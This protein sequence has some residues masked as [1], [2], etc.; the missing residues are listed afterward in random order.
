[1]QKNKKIQLRTTIFGG[2]IFL[3]I[4]FGINA[5]MIYAFDSNNKLVRKTA[6]YIPYPVAN[7]GT[8]FISFAELKD[9]LDSVRMFYE[10]QDFSDLGLRVDFVTND[11]K[12]RLKIKEKQ[13]LQ[14]LIENKL[15]EN[16]VIKRGLAMQP[17]D[18]SQEVSRE[19]QKYDSE[20]YLKNNMARLYGWNIQ[21][22]ENNI[23][24]PDMYQKRLASNLRENDPIS[25]EAKKKITLALEDLNNRNE[26]DVV[27]KKYSEGESAK[28][29]GDLGWFTSAELLTEI[30]TAAPNLKIGERSDIIES[31]LGYHIILMEDKKTEEGVEKFKLGQVFVRTLNFSDWLFEYQ[32]NINIRIFSK[33]MYW[34]KTTGQVEF[35]NKDLKDFEDNLRTNSAG[36]VSVLF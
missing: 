22:F 30:A 18:I 1:M 6:K 2:I 5:I 34:D 20:E 9:N 16:E 19:M 11:G 4:Y 3:L 35:E 7:W 17:E 27:A 36:D 14:K 21:D 25:V 8:N 24:K 15:I 26:F 28:N 31:Q 32:K 29:G 23:V 12:K 13:V 33:D 10:N